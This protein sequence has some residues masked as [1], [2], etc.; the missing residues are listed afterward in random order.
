MKTTFKWVMSPVHNFQRTKIVIVLRA[1][2]SR[3]GIDF[4][5]IAY[6][7]TGFIVL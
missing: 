4:V 2:F 7:N 5:Y 1:G 3:D 6:V